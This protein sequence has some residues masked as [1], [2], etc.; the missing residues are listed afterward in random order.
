MADGSNLMV[1]LVL[2]VGLTGGITS[3]LGALF[4]LLCALELVAW[5]GL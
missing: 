2:K 4:P 5:S 1:H 3:L